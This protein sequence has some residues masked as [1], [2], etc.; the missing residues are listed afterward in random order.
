MKEKIA[1]SEWK[2]MEVLWVQKEAKSAQVVEALF[3]TGWSDKTIK[4]L[5]SRLQKKGLIDFKKEGRGYIYFPLVEKSDC[6]EKESNDFVEKIFGGS[7]KAFMAN[8][9]KR[10]NLSES[11]IEELRALLD[12]KEKE[13]G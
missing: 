5:L 12:E 7:G 2:V 11:D 1:T 6:I 3:N 4:T 9:L 8:F 13:E 10:E